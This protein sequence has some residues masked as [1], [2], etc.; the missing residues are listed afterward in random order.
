MRH[1]QRREFLFH[2]RSR[3]T[4]LFVV[5]SGSL[6]LTAL[7]REGREQIVAFLL[8]GDIAGLDSMGIAT[9]LTTAVALEESSVIEVPVEEARQLCVTTGRV[10]DGLLDSLG[11]QIRRKQSTL[12]LL[13]SQSADERLARFLLDL[14]QRLAPPGT[15]NATVLVPMT[16]Q[17]MGSYLGLK[18]ETV[19]RTLS[20]LCRYGAIER[21]PR[22]LRLCN[23]DRLQEIADC[24]TRPAKS[25][26]SPA[27]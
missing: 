8:P 1:L 24:E 6:K 23:V 4:S 3:F 13:G 18:L 27:G 14:W 20:R 2:S 22:G 12:V 19:S 21:V 15:G 16:R 17:E 5:R 11:V 10:R 9:H 7:T 25:K 26:T